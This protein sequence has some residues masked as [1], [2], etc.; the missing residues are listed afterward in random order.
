MTREE[1]LKIRRERARLQVRIEE[2]LRAAGLDGRQLVAELL[3]A[4]SVLR[5]AWTDLS[6]EDRMA[7]ILADNTETD[8]V[9]RESREARGAAGAGG[10]T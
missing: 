1:Y 6:H 9:I 4:E 10:R 5:R 8:R 7:T 2:I 3:D